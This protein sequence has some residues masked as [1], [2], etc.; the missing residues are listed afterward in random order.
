MGARLIAQVD[1]T[2]DSVHK[3]EEIGQG[4]IKKKYEAL[5]TAYLDADRLLAELEREIANIPFKSDE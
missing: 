1:K 4:E 3:A 2:H 5:R